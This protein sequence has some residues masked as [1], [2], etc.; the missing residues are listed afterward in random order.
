[1]IAG[2]GLQVVNGR[3]PGGFEIA[4]F[5]LHVVNGWSP[6]VQVVKNRTRIRRLADRFPSR[7]THPYIL[8][9]P[10]SQIFIRQMADSASLRI[11]TSSH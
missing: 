6:N 11:L 9:L 3:S 8:K 2:F 5:G 1:M 7:Q 4:G 10:N